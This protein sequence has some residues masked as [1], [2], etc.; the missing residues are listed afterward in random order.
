MGMAQ[1]KKSMRE[2]YISAFRARQI[3]AQFKGK[4]LISS[5]TLKRM[6]RRFGLPS[7][8]DPYGGIFPVYLESEILAWDEAR[9]NQAPA[10]NRRGPGRP[11][12]SVKPTLP[13]PSSSYQ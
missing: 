8:P 1:W 5:A 10:S 13:L 11:I 6:V 7:H 12:G 3:V 2:A 9:R 4:E